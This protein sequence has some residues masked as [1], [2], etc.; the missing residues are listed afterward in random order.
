M[1]PSARHRLV[2][3]S[4]EFRSAA[5]LRG[6]GSASDAE[7]LE[8]LRDDDSVAVTR[9]V[10]MAGANGLAVCAT[11][12]LPLPGVPLLECRRAVRKGPDSQ[13]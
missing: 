8:R 11:Y 6:Q 2:L 13:L 4:G 5:A 3:E 10:S 1:G 12:G 7:A 9:V